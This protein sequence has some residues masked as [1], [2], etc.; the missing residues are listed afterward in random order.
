MSSRHDPNVTVS[1][2][3]EG[4]AHF[5]ATVQ[6]LGD[7]ELAGASGLPNWS[8][9]HVIGHVARNAEALVRLASWARTGVENPMYE[10][11]EQRNAEISST[12]E[13]PAA[14]L[15]RLLVDTADGLRE[16]L[17]ALNEETWHAIVKSALGRTIPAAEIPWMRI[18]EVWLHAI[19][20]GADLGLADFPAGVVDLL[21]DDTVTALSARDGCPA[22][23]LAPHDREQTWQLGPAD[24]S[25]GPAAR[26]DADA[27]TI[28]AWLTGRL[29]ADARPARLPD[30]PDWI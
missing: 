16:A 30:I 11:R 3:E 19:D 24:Q 21:I 17:G 15:R 8:R 2:M 4:T 12:A 10:S 20:L 28:A 7:D 27:A 9:A 26:V 29:A 5:L 14:E 18:R 22:V 1:W 13:L 25:D 23:T 6:R